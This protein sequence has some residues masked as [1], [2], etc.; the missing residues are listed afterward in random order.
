MLIMFLAHEPSSVFVG[1]IVYAKDYAT[2]NVQSG[3]DFMLCTQSGL[4]KAQCTH[5][6]PT[7]KTD[8]DTLLSLKKRI[9][10]VL[11]SAELG[12]VTT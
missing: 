7:D 6:D 2:T 4:E 9:C 11:A 5:L 3:E 12:A 1:K 10:E 8:T